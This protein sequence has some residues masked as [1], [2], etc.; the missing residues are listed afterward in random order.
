MTVVRLVC[1]ARLMLPAGS[2]RASDVP[3]VSLLRE[4]PAGV[5]VRMMTGTATA[6]N[7]PGNLLIGQVDRA[8][9]DGDRLL[10]LG[11]DGTT[12]WECRIG[13]SGLLT[14]FFRAPDGTTLVTQVR[15]GLVSRVLVLD[16]QGGFRRGWSVRGR[17]A[18]PPP[19]IAT[20]Q[21]A[22]DG[23]LSASVAGYAFAVSRRGRLTMEWTFGKLK[24]AIALLDGRWLAALAR[25]E[26]FA[27]YDPR[28]RMLATLPLDSFCHVWSAD[29][30]EAI[31]P[32]RFRLF[33]C[34]CMPDGPVTSTQVRPRLTIEVADIDAGG[35]LLATYGSPHALR[36]D[37][38]GTERCATFTRGL[39]RLP[40]GGMVLANTYPADCRV[41]ERDAAG[42]VLRI[43]LAASASGGNGTFGEDACP[44]VGL[45]RIGAEGTI[46]SP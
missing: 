31:G 40:S 16:R 18:E 24:S 9:G 26:R 2:A 25:P 10:E 35:G 42:Q 6:F 44:L 23:G 33:G 45:Q 8:S 11:P 43:L 21:P 38:F 3:V 7:A 41:E 13:P 12:V 28:T 46:I 36:V 4:V 37:E 34:F 30:A 5:R 19:A 27:L 15:P 1:L 39:V 14:G 17:G 29:R 22:A 20:A 32:A